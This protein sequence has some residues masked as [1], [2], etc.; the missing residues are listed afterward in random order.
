MTYL[1]TFWREFWHAIS[2][3][4]TTREAWN[5]AREEVGR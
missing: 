4:K 2:F 5:Y 1:R 3:G